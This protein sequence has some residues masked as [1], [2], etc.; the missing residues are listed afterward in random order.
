MFYIYFGSQTNE[1]FSINRGNVIG[2]NNT[3]VHGYATASTDSGNNQS[4]AAGGYDTSFTYLNLDSM[5]TNNIV[6]Q[7]DQMVIAEPCIPGYY[8]HYTNTNINCKYNL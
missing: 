6:E 3:E 5:E 8:V 2:L 1:Q 7:N 4:S